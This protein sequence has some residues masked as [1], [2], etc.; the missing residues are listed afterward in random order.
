MAEAREQFENSEEGESAQLQSVTGTLVKTVAEGTC[1]RVRVCWGA[2]NSDLY[3]V[4][5]N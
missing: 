3:N 5:T 2:C 1:A 4:V